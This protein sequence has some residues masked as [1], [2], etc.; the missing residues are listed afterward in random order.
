MEII[1]EKQPSCSTGAM[2]VIIVLA[3]VLIGLAAA[4][5]YLLLSGQGNNYM[6]GTLLAFEFFIGGIVIIVYARFFMPFREVSEDREEEL[7]W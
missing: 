4:F 3:V 7:L 5:S 6:L 2:V 1:R